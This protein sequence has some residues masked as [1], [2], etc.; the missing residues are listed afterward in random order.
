MTIN[1]TSE[2]LN[3]IHA[4]EGYIRCGA[5]PG[6]GKTYCITKR[7]AYLI[8]DLY[9]D[10]SSIVAL[11]FTN[12]AAASMTRRLKKM[13]G[14]DA[15]CFTG[16]FHGYCNKILKE[17][18]YRLSY[19]KE[20]TIL[21]AKD[22]MDLIREIATELNIS[23]KDN[24]AKALKD[25]IDQQKIGGGYISPYM[26]G[27]DK[28]HLIAAMSAAGNDFTKV[29]FRYLLKQRDNYVLDFNDI[30]EFA[31]HILENYPDALAK[32]QEKCMYVLCDEFQDVSNRQEHLLE[33]L[34]GKY[35][36]LTVV[37][38]DDQCIYGWRGSKVDYIVNFDSK[39][40]KAKDF[41]LSENFRST[42]EI[43]AAANTLIA[44]NQNRLA[45]HMYTNNPSGLKPVY[46][47]LKIEKDEAD[48]IADT[49]LVHVSQG[50]HYSDHAVLVRASSQARALEESFIR[51]K[52]PYKILSGAEFYG[53][54]EIKTVLAY[55]R[56]VY[57]LNNLDFT[58]TIQRPR[59][60]YG[61]KFK[62][63]LE[64]Y[65]EQRNLPLIA[66]LGEQI[67]NGM[68]K[69]KPE[70]IK[71][72]NDIM[73]LH[74]TYHK[75]SSKDLANMVLDFGYRA[76]LQQDVEQQRLD[77][78]SELLETITALEK[79]NGEALALDE[80]LSHF[81]LFSQQDDDTDKDVVKVMT[82]HTAKGLEFDTVFVNGLVEGQ[83]PSKKIKRQEEM[84]EERRLFYVAITRAKKMLYLSGYEA[85]SGSY[86]TDQSSFLRDI[87]EGLL[88]CI[89]NSRIGRGYAAFVPLPIALYHIG[90]RVL[91]KAFGYGTVTGVDEIGQ[92]YEIDFD[93]LG[94]KRRIQFRAE[95]MKV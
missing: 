36:N 25:Y 15:T 30:I 46:N 53:S 18:I 17:E 75:Y 8:T 56:M 43:I 44:K 82:I 28:T 27:A 40:P 50:K 22:Q 47:N 55:L 88:D 93:E 26:A 57:S 71:Y 61:K 42:P 84:E 33:L 77:N 85:K 86:F 23:L 39:Y 79:E 89:N 45:K 74:N 58:Y 90:D 91:H 7:M 31:L 35:H 69:G 3:A 94:Q 41:P 51:K 48:W 76:A 83:F 65:A 63:S 59:R 13:I 32:W 80:L 49:V 38:D 37:G 92:I 19:P 10:P 9:V 64:A 1:S 52:V 67:N 54:E 24:T 21:D 62:E 29:W 11:T 68:I 72:Y 70:I 14:D 73:A 2:Q 4:T 16:T 78:V 87:G 60:G 20:F 66:A 95:L 5:V 34:S 12:K 6:S 81:A